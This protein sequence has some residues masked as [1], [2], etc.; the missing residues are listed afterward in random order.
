MRTL[1]KVHARKGFTLVEVLVVMAIML[2]LTLI[3]VQGLQTFAYRTGYISAARTVF[4][5]LEE[6]QARTLASDGSLAYG[7]HFETDSVTIF[8]GSTY[9]AGTVTNDVR[10]L[11]ARTSIDNIA[12]VG[13]TNNIIFTRL[14]GTTSSSGTVRVIVT[15]NSSL[16]RTITIYKTG[17]SEIQG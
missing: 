13:G 6:A 10:T 7:V 8:Q 9:T 17:F 2:I 3:S 4:G 1:E 5:A 15:S 11:P 16:S 12:L 14:T